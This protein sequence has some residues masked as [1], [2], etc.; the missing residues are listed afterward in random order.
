MIVETWKVKGIFKAD[1]HL[2]A[3]EIRSIGE[4]ATPQQIVDFAKGKDTELHKCFEWDNKKAADKYRLY[5]A[6]QICTN[7]IIKKQDEDASPDEAP[8]RVFYKTSASEGYKDSQIIFRDEDEYSQ[9]LKRALA[10]LHAFKLK[11]SRLSELDEIL[12]LID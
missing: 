3:E 6:R 1:P 7:L 8:I 10:E 2:V 5:Q 4:D 12:S 11:Y 9:L